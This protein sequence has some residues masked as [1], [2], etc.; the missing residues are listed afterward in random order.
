MAPCE[1]EDESLK[2]AVVHLRH[3]LYELVQCVQP[4]LL[5]AQ[6][7]S[8]RDTPAK[9]ITHEKPLQETEKLRNLAKN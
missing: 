9:Y 7:W 3:P 6:V 2:D 8:K 5:A 1:M 4:L